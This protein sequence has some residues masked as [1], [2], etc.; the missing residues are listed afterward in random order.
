MVEEKKI[1][2]II[3]KKEKKTKEN[4]LKNKEK[5]ENYLKNKE[6][7]E[8]KIE[9]E[10][11]DL[12]EEEEEEEEEEKYINKNIIIYYNKIIYGP[13]IDK[14][15]NGDYYLDEIKGTLEKGYSDNKSKLFKINN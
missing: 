12:V 9:E 1:E 2:N 13:I 4:Y 14:L 7:K 15:I 11:E 8:N 5:K 6:K 3:Q 10:K